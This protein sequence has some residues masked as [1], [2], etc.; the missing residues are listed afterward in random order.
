MELDSEGIIRMKEGVP[1]EEGPNTT[2]VG[3]RLGYLF[4]KLSYVF[5]K[6]DEMKPGDEV[7]IRDSAGKE[8]TFRV[9]DFLTVR[10]EDY[11]V[12]YPIPGKTMVSLQT[13]DPIPTFENRLIVRAELV[14]RPRSR[15]G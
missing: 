10:P 13:C 9:H 6:L 1:W 14:E 11:W 8:Y 4:T 7:T 5:Y 2:M 3:H 15:L 12:T